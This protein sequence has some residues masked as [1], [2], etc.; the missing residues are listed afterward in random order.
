MEELLHDR[1]VVGTENNDV[2]K[3]LSDADLNLNKAVQ[4]CLDSES[5]SK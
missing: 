5:A 4:I 1:I 3:F 2:K